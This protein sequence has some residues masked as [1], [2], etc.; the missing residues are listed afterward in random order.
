[1]EINPQLSALAFGIGIV[2]LLWVFRRTVARL[3]RLKR[4]PDEQ[5]YRVRSRSAGLLIDEISAREW[6][7]KDRAALQIPRAGV[8]LTAVEH[9]A[10]ARISTMQA[11]TG[12]RA[13]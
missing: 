3:A 5:S 13:D 9:A 8:E 1:M 11:A 10:L 7:K 6:L 4:D 12:R 2:A